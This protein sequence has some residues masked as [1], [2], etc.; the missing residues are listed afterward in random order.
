MISSLYSGKEETNREEIEEA[1]RLR[2]RE[3][4]IN[5]LNSIL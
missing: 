4:S 5:L 3:G 1:K 2:R